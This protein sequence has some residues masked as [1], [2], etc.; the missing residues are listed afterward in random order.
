MEVQEKKRRRKNRGGQVQKILKKLFQN[1]KSSYPS[2]S[3]DIGNPSLALDACLLRLLPPLPPPVLLLAAALVAAAAAALLA[4]SAARA[5]ALRDSRRPCT[6]F[7][8]QRSGRSKKARG[9]RAREA[10]RAAGSWTSA[11]AA[12]EEEK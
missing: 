3:G 1:S 8:R 4:A 2:L 7:L 10:A 6:V 9:S 12:A 5:R 11:A